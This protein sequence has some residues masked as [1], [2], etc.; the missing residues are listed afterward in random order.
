MART[1]HAMSTSTPRADGLRLPARFVEHA[2]HAAVLAL[3]GGRLRTAAGTGQGGVGRG[4]A[5][6][7]ALRAGRRCVARPEDADEARGAVRRR[8]STCSALP[9]DDSWI[10]DNGPIFVRDERGAVARRRLRLR[11]LE[12][13]VRSLRRR[14]ARPGAARR[15]LGRALLPGA[16]RARG[17]RLQHRRRGHAADDRAVP[18][19]Q[20]QPRHVAARLRGGAARV[21]GH[22]EGRSGCPSGWS[23]TPAR[24]RPPGHV[25]DVAQFVAPGVVLAQTAPPDN[26]N[27]ARLRENLE[28]SRA[29]DRRRRPPAGGRRDGR[30]CRT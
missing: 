28:A 26:P 8:A 3:P 7:R 20:P 1:Q 11:R 15:G 30:C 29:G 12:P 21:A 24:S 17:R 25:D 19:A 22:R 16:V 14:R 5:R 2:A 9:L 13:A 4:G 27:H 18:A 10:R 23:R 6:D